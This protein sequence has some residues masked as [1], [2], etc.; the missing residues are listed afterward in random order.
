ML[1]DEATFPFAPAEKYAWPGGYPLG[2]FVADGE[3]LC[4]DCVNDP[5]NPVT[6]HDAENDPAWNVVFCGILDDPSDDEICA[7]CGTVIVA[8][9]VA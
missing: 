8:R 5:T 4:A 2:Y 6:F 7:H 9:E 1:F 3:T